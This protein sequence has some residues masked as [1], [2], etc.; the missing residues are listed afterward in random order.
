MQALLRL[1]N[2]AV[3]SSESFWDDVSGD[4]ISVF[5]PIWDEKESQY[6]VF[7]WIHVQ[8]IL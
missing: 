7:G 5:F 1:N 6:K 4:G 2:L 8:G 3:L